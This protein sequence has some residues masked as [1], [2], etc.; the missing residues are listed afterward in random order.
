[1]VRSILTNKKHHENK[2]KK[3]LQTSSCFEINPSITLPYMT[4]EL[5]SYFESLKGS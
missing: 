3:P 1:M 2:K 5:A 4:T